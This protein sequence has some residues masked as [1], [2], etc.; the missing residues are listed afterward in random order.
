MHTKNYS[1]KKYYLIILSFLKKRIIV[2]S[3]IARSVYYYPHNNVLLATMLSRFLEDFLLFKYAGT[4]I[5]IVWH[6]KN[7]IPFSLKRKSLLKFIIF[8]L[9]LNVN[10]FEKGVFKFIAIIVPLKEVFVQG[11]RWQ[12]TNN[13]CRNS[14]M[15]ES[16][17][18]AEMLTPRGRPKAP[19]LPNGS[20]E[21]LRAAQ[22]IFD[23][24]QNCS[25]KRWHCRVC[26]FKTNVIHSVVVICVIQ[27]SFTPTHSTH[28]CHF[29]THKDSSAFR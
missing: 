14:R 11:I 12:S 6:F 20:Q 27:Q 22:R 25:R 9:F 19:L 29:F 10:F 5:Q 21:V 3:Y 7:P 2:D 15:D 18:K 8:N 13:T 24:V 28:L 1:K 26:V 17:L 4:Q 16:G 23:I